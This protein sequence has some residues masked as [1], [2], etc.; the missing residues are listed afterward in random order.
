NLD[1]EAHRVDDVVLGQHMVL[2]RVLVVELLVELVPPYAT[3]I[4][5]PRCEEHGIE[6]L[7]RALEGYRLARHDDGI[8][9]GEGRLA[10][11]FVVLIAFG[12]LTLF[13]LETIENDVRVEAISIRLVDY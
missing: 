7:L 13:L 12:I 11:R 3:K 1:K 5:A 10:S 6:V 2:R 9:C 8:D 4:V